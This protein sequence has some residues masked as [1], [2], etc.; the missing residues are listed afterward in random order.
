M[1]AR[2]LVTRDLINNGEPRK[3]GF[4][5]TSGLPVEYDNVLFVD[6]TNEIE[7]LARTLEERKEVQSFRAMPSKA[8]QS[9]VKEG[10]EPIWEGAL[11]GKRPILYPVPVALVFIFLFWG[12]ATQQFIE[13]A[14]RTM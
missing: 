9:S 1:A 12:I 6:G 4:F 10:E 5:N 11:I 2:G 7:N 13:V 14:P 8:I 3:Q